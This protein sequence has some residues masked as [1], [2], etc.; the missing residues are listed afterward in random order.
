MHR[1][2]SHQSSPWSLTA[3]TLW[4]RPGQVC[5]QRLQS[6]H[7]LRRR[8][9][10]SPLLPYTY[11]LVSCFFSYGFPNISQVL[12]QVYPHQGRGPCAGNRHSAGTRRF[13]CREQGA[14]HCDTSQHVVSQQASLTHCSSRCTYVVE[15][16]VLKKIQGTVCYSLAS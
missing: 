11:M 6:G 4:S 3:W 12:A 7:P 2:S 8:G 14:S 16:T 10:G 15:D 1:G 9:H 13:A 5:H